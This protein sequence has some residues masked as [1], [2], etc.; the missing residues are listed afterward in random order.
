MIWT[1][2]IA[3]AWAIQRTTPKMLETR[4]AVSGPMFPGEIAP[5]A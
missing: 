2:Q 4:I 1:G 5:N 3:T